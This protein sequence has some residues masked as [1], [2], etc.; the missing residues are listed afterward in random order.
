[1]YSKEERE[2]AIRLYIK[3]DKCAADVIRELGYP[4]RKTLRKWY[5]TYIG[6]W[7]IIRTVFTTALSIRWNKKKLLWNTTLKHGRN[8]SRTIRALGYPSEETLRAWCNELVPDYHKKRVGSI[9]K[10][11]YPRAEK[12]SSN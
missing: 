8:F 4:D 5:K 11:V 2:K 6:N 1:M 3:Y 9:Q 7:G 10:K 12:R